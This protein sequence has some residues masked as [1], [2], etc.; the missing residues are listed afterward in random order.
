MLNKKKWSSAVWQLLLVLFTLV[1]L[2]PLIYMVLNSF[3]PYSQMLKDPWGLP[4]TLFLD[5]YI[6]AF[7]QMKF[8]QSLYN[9]A[10]ITIASVFLIV[11]LGGLAAYPITRF[12]NRLTRFLSVYFLIG[13]M[14]P[15]QV[16]IVQIFSVMKKMHLIN[17]KTGLILV[18]AAGV[19]F[20]VFMYQGFIRSMPVDME[21]SALIDGARPWQMFWK[22]VF[23]LLKPASA[24]LIIFQ[25]MWI[26]NDFVLS[27][28]FLSS[29]KNLTLVLELHQCIGEF[30]LDWS[31]MLA[32]MCIVMLPML[33]FYLLM[34][35]QI[36][37]GMTAGAVKG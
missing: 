19:S 29:R 32:I 27:S 34:Q 8:F 11:V 1:F 22:V 3:K 6:K 20:A 18:Y 2:S 30:S 23:P 15:T 7:R 17:T 12:D 33:V 13:Y 10:V 36:I 5:N 26:W 37:A 21:E 4:Q 9:S 35:K 24:T 16:L 31:V 14:V 28:L 25:T